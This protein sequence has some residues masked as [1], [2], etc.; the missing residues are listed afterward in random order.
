MSKEGTHFIATGIYTKHVLE[1]LKA[2]TRHGAFIWFLCLFAAFLASAIACSPSTH[3]NPELGKMNAK[4]E[5]KAHLNPNNG[6]NPSTSDFTD[7]PGG[8][9]C[10]HS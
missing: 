6:S 9:P 2:G 1:E 3:V 10:P 8:T 7:G 5:F 4:Q